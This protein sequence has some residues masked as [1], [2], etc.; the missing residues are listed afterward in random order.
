MA[1]STSA[2][3][4]ND[5][6]EERLKSSLRARPEKAGSGSELSEKSASASTSSRESKSSTGQK[7]R[8]I[9]SSSNKTAIADSFDKN[10][11]DASPP[12][13]YSE[14][15]NEFTL[16][17]IQQ[18][19]A[20]PPPTLRN[21]QNEFRRALEQGVKVMAVQNRFADLCRTAGESKSAEVSGK[22]DVSLNQ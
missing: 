2:L 17:P 12:P 7:D 8:R 6:L 5:G 4:L 21:A 1:A 13:T 19:S 15:T 16:D 14:A 11:E 3:S 9:T 20:F 18:F 22:Q 10:G